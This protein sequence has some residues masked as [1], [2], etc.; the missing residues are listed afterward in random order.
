MRIPLLCGGGRVRLAAAL[1]AASCLCGAAERM[2]PAGGEFQCGVNFG[3]YAREGYYESAAAR[4]EVDEMVRTGVKWVT[5]IATVFQETWCSTLQYRDFAE[6]P[7][8]LELKEIIDYIHSKGL[9]VCLRPMEEAQDGTDRCRICFPSDAER[10]PGKRVDHASRWFDSMRKR[11]RFYAKIAAKTG[12]EAYCLD[13]EIN[14]IMPYNDEWRGVIAAVREVY[15]GP[16]TS[17]HPF[18]RA[19]ERW[20]KDPNC[21]LRDLDFLSLSDYTSPG[22]KPGAGVEAMRKGLGPRRDF[23]RKMAAATGMKI[24]FGEVGCTSTAGAAQCPWGWKGNGGYDG[25]E[26]A[27]FM[28]AVFS[29]YENEPWCLGF[30]WWKWDEQ[31]VRPQFRDDP[32]GDKGFTVRGKPAQDVMRRHY[33]RH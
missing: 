25:K 13:S 14:G 33:Q 31:N 23:L 1:L 2:L 4:A 29:L 7:S 24:L 3:F 6:S 18:D 12:C 30:M 11:S 8:D 21:W 16:V 28:E 20:L 5:V 27:D 22:T 19:F 9:K 32:A 17:C 10:I 26:Q 15:K